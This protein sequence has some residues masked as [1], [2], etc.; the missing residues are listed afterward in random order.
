M[1]PDLFLSG[2]SFH[3]AGCLSHGIVFDPSPVFQC[4]VNARFGFIL[5]DLINVC[6]LIRLMGLFEPGIHSHVRISAADDPASRN[7]FVRILSDNGFSVL[8]EK[9]SHSA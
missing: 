2:M 7:L 4:F 1:A 9:H 3:P 8:I 5:H 6:I